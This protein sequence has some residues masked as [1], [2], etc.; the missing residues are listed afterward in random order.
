VIKVKQKICCECNQLS[1]IFSKGRCKQC[2]S[3]SYK[4]PKPQ[5]EKRKE[6]TK[7]YTIKRLRFLS[8]PENQRCPITM[9]RATEVHHIYSGSNRSRYYL[10]EST[11][12]AVSRNGHLWIHSNPIEAR[13]MGYLKSY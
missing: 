3:K 11:W 4:K 2:A 10:D 7:E 5:S 6:E 13:E 1:Y 12:V 9:E 8:Q